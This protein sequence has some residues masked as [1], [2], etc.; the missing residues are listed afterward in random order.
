MPRVFYPGRMVLIGL[1]FTAIAACAGPTL[2][3]VQVDPAAARQEIYKQREMALIALVEDHVRLYRVQQRISIAAHRDCAGHTVPAVGI[4]VL[5][6]ATV[7]SE[8][9][10]VA[11]TALGLGSAAELVDVVPGSPAD[12]A[13][14]RRGDIVRS[15]GNVRIPENEAATE[16]VAEMIGGTANWPGG[17]PFV[18]E[19]DGQRM[20][21]SVEPDTQC[22]YPVNLTRQDMVNAFAD[23]KQ[24]IITQGLLRFTANDDELALVL[25]HEYAHNLLRHGEAQRQNATTGALVGL[26][27]DVLAAAAGVN[28]QGGFSD[29]GASAGAGAYSQDF[30]SEADYMG[31]YIFARAEFDLSRGPNFFRRLGAANPNSI[32]YAT[33][34]PT[35]V[36]RV[37]ALEQVAR[38][39]EAKR[40]AGLPLLPDAGDDPSAVIVAVANQPTPSPRPARRIEPTETVLALAPSAR[41]PAPPALRVASPG[42]EI[43]RSGVADNACGKS[44]SMSLTRDGDRVVGQIRRDGVLY[45]L[46]GAIDPDSGAVR[47]ARAGK[48][49]ESSARPGPRTLGL[50]ADFDAT[51]SGRLWVV[52]GGQRSCETYFTL[53]ANS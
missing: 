41:A 39:I 44:W 42:S 17:I 53:S 20:A 8:F 3:Q 1:A 19:R 23:G 28:T 34:H 46:K 24:V 51:P 18:I 29:I 11:G 10:A 25:A 38:E 40:V 48:A 27:F 37:L 50:E 31:L 7:G 6:Q 13:G 14:L 12:R 36:H 26:V 22:A 4:F 2:K 47:E 30:E 45:D 9:R 32:A 35:T 21:L 52:S 33:S 5:N 15:I 16:R 49:L 43:W